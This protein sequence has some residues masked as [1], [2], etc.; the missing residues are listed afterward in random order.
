MSEIEWGLTLGIVRTSSAM[1][2][3]CITNSSTAWPADSL[4][5]MFPIFTLP[6]FFSFMRDVVGMLIT[7][8]VRELM[9]VLQKYSAKGREVPLWLIVVLSTSLICFPQPTTTVK[10]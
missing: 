9:S 3:S 1:G 10:Y 4:I 2:T 5:S 6:D 8:L 7:K